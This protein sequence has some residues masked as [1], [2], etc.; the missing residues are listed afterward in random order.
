MLAQQGQNMSG[1]DLSSSVLLSAKHPAAFYLRFF[2]CQLFSCRLNSSP[3]SHYLKNSSHR[4]L[5]R[6]ISLRWPWWTEGWSAKVSLKALSTEAR[7]WYYP[8]TYEN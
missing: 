1:R 3:K 5:Y 6:K 8:F 4:P 2:H 7:F